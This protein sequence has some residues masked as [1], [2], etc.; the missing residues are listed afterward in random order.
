MNTRNVGGA[1]GVL[2]KFL[3]RGL[4]RRRLAGGWGFGMVACVVRLGVG[5]LRRFPWGGNMSEGRS[6]L[7]SNT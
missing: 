1:D 2:G 6:A 4:V 5:V 3:V 7:S